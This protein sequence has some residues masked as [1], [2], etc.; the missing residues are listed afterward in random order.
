MR[1]RRP[2]AACPQRSTGQPPAR[3]PRSQIERSLDPERRTRAWRWA[4]GRARR[5]VSCAVGTEGDLVRR[6]RPE[7]AV[8]RHHAVCTISGRPRA[9][10]RDRGDVDVREC[11]GRRASEPSRAEGLCVWGVNVREPVACRGSR[12]PPNQVGPREARVRTKSWPFAIDVIGCLGSTRR[13]RWQPTRRR[14]RSS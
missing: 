4:C 1:S 2:V 6:S 5:A 14:S 13:L 7:Q 12:Y 8:H 10:P 9:D 11:E 3:A